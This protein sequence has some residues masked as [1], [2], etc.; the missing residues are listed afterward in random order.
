MIDTFYQVKLRQIWWQMISLNMMPALPLTAKICC[1]FFIATRP[2]WVHTDVCWDHVECTFNKDRVEYCGDAQFL[3]TEHLKVSGYWSGC[4]YLQHFFSLYWW[5]SFPMAVIYLPWKELDLTEFL[6]IFLNLFLI[7]LNPSFILSFIVF[8]NPIF[9][10]I[11][12]IWVDNATSFTDTSYVV[13]WW[14]WRG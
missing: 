7:S 3:Q 12:F 1:F 4:I 14:L 9:A 5:L 11:E 10:S 8:S 6:L 13:I 2:C